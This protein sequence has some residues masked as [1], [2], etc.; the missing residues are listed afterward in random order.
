MAGLS[1]TA[2][3]RLMR[4]TAITLTLLFLPASTQSGVAFAQPA[5]PDARLTP[6]QRQELD[7]IIHVITS[8]R[9]DRQTRRFGAERL[10]RSDLPTRIENTAALLCVHHSNFRIVG[11]SQDVPLEQM[12][13]C[14]H[15][16]NLIAIND[17]GSGA[18]FDFTRLGLPPEP[19]VGQSLA[20]GV[21]ILCFSGDKLLGGPQAGIILGRKD[22]TR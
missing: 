9:N 20:A 16:H 3:E 1:V 14:A 21:D 8:E 5:G 2:H 11:F 15:D 4:T 22:L 17:L 12:V 13:R 18:T 7:E 6:E 10:L 19:H